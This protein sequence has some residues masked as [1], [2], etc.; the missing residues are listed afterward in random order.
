[1]LNRLRLLQA[2]TALLYFGPLLAGLAGAVWAT[3]PLFAIAFV[4]WSVILRPHLWPAKLSD[5]L[6]AQALIAMA[7]LIATQILLVTL[8]FAVGRGMGGVMGLRPALP[9][10]LP[11]ALSFLSVPLSRLVWRPA[12]IETIAGFD[13]LSHKPAPPEPAPRAENRAETLLAGVLALPDTVPEALPDTVPEA[14]LQAHLAAIATHV[15]ALQIR[16]AFENAATAQRL[17][18]A[19]KKALILHATDPAVA[20][21]LSGSAYP[22][23]AF[24]A[25]GPDPDLQSLFAIR[26]MRL[27]TEAPTLAPDCPKPATLTEAART[28]P[29]DPQTRL[30][31]LAAVIARTAP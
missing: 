8:C 17:T 20:D 4:L 1:M 3:I 29:P 30:R 7:A 10:Y 19:G 11:L 25:A 2:T 24:T 6:K 27:V 9:P 15:D 13:P 26:C 31:H 22:A 14:D 21:L 16:R 28:A 12:E 23:H 18:P 5:L